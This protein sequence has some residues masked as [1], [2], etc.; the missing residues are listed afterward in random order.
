M[1]RTKNKIVIL[2][3]T[4]CKEK[5]YQGSNR[6]DRKHILPIKKNITWVYPVKNGPDIIMHTIDLATS[7]KFQ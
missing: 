6:K 7:S 1:L 4:Q 3:G 5:I 2:L